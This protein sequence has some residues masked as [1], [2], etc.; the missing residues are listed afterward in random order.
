MYERGRE[1][2]QEGENMTSQKKMSLGY[3]GGYT[4]LSAYVSPRLWGEG[5]GEEFSLVPWTFYPFDRCGP[6]DA[7]SILLF[8]RYL[9]HSW[10][11]MP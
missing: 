10:Y 9:D 8:K 3:S 4:F 2:G 5:G 1:G 11:S 7:A 6:L